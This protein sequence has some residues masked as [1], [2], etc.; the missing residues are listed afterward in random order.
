MID[1]DEQGGFIWEMMGV[2]DVVCGYA[3]VD[4]R[5]MVIG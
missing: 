5:M 1:D 4:A 3:E 2:C